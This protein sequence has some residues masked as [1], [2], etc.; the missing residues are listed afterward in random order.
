[1]L[2]SGLMLLIE[3]GS[4]FSVV[5][6]LNI[7]GCYSPERFS[8]LLGESLILLHLYLIRIL[9]FFIMGI[10]NLNLSSDYGL[11]LFVLGLSGHFAFE[12]FLLPHQDSQIIL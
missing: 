1:M 12:S 4:H 7:S 9:V 3:S 5:I 8:L 10:M 6:F 2:L 11:I